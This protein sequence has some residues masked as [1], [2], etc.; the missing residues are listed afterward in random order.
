[1]DISIFQ[2]LP[3]P[4]GRDAAEVIAQA[5]WEIDFAERNGFAG[6]W[7]AEHH[8]S[9]FGLVGAPSVWA[10]TI[11]AR[12]SR[13]RI[14][15]GI[16]VLPLHHPLR[17]A[18]EIRW[19]DHLSGGR[20]DVG[21]GPGFSA[22]EFAALGVALEERHARFE[23]S[24][25]IIRRALT[26]RELSYDGRFWSFPAVTLEPPPFT[27]PHPPFYRAVSSIETARLAASQR[28]PMLLG[29]KT[30]AEL[31][32]LLAAYRDA[33]GNASST[34]VLRRFTA[35]DFDAQIDGLAAIGVEHVIGWFHHAGV[36]YADVRRAMD[37]AANYSSRSMMT[38]STH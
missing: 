38:T 2:L 28:L 8:L 23:E 16:A 26:E 6:I 3:R 37:V 29:T 4:E 13:I 25:E 15:Y 11:A 14:G 36:E 1:M 35:D 22:Y 7:I 34:C 9:T 21:T 19:L 17:L 20:I 24:L 27:M 5:F 30:N 10:A 18:E 31:A 33:G 32:E 12:T